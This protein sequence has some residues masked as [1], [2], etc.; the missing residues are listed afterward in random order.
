MPQFGFDYDPFTFSDFTGGMSKLASKIDPHLP[1][2]YSN[3]I[4]EPIK[5]AAK[6]GFESFV[7]QS[8][9][10]A[11]M[12]TSLG[13]P[14]GGTALNVP[15][16]ALKMMKEDLLDTLPNY[17]TES[18]YVQAAK[19]ILSKGNIS[20]YLGGAGQFAAPKNSDLAAAGLGAE[21]TSMF[22]TKDIRDSFSKLMYSL[23]KDP[24]VAS[25]TIPMLRQRISGKPGIVIDEK[26][27]LDQF[28]ESAIH[29]L[30]HLGQDVAPQGSMIKTVDL[31]HQSMKDLGKDIQYPFIPAEI[32]VRGSKRA[33]PQLVGVEKELGRKLTMDEKFGFAGRML[34]TQSYMLSAPT[35]EAD[36]FLNEIMPIIRNYGKF[37]PRYAAPSFPR[38]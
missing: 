27:P 14:I 36:F 4:P 32:L 22:P 8:A 26:V 6:F 18:K 2:A 16:K 30:G 37:D 23:D 9:Q 38:R 11:I 21:Y 20:G 7:P 12:P 10:E 15:R 3:W 28:R 19:D 35:E 33:N 24:E 1:E 17:I 25:M 29:E 31:R 5:K 13:M 34:G